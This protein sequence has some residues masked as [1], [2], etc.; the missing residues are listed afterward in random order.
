MAFYPV[1]KAHCTFSWTQAD[2]K[3]IATTDGASR[4]WQPAGQ[5]DLFPAL[6][7]S[8]LRP[9]PDLLE[10]RPNVHLVEVGI[11]AWFTAE[12]SNMVFDITGTI[13]FDHFVDDE[14]NDGSDEDENDEEDSDDDEA[15]E[16]ASF[17]FSMQ[18]KAPAVATVLPAEHPKTGAAVISSCVV[19]VDVQHRE[20]KVRN[21]EL[22]FTFV[23]S[24]DVL[25]KNVIP[26]SVG[27]LP[28]LHDPGVCDC[29]FLTKGVDTPLLASRVILM[30]A[31]P[32]LHTMLSG[33]WA[34][35]AKLATKEPISLKSW[36]A[37][38]VALAFIHIYSGWTP[39]QPTLPESTPEDLV[40]DFACDPATLDEDAWRH[41]LQLA[42]FLGLKLLALA[43]NRKLIKLL[44]EQFE[45]LNAMPD[46]PVD[47][48]RPR[49]RKRRQ[50][51][52]PAMTEEMA[53]HLDHTPDM[54][55][56]QTDGALSAP[57]SG[58]DGEV[59]TPAG[60]SVGWV[61]C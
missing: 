30:R 37:T 12:L 36:D 56:S 45:E 41:L 28:Y 54:V 11:A 32:I 26:A 61:S 49:S 19:A 34:E 35:S 39:D 9:T 3:L 40:D 42:R 17:P 52:E 46:E 7:P 25:R 8:E 53:P 4:D 27:L 23:A 6:Q 18:L 2:L 43:V 47:V 10:K 22:D 15:G 21:L 16:R 20:K 31:S 57:S 50:L 60:E 38:A 44:E 1:Q 58:S 14:S 48:P 59:A 29:S 33:P 24:N 13:S 5:I 55:P 51:V